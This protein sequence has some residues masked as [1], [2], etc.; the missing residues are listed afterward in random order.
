[1]T[2]IVTGA[3]GCI[4]YHIVK[5]LNDQDV[6]PVVLIRQSSNV[7]KLDGLKCHIYRADLANF[8]QL[9]YVVKQ[10]L[11]GHPP[12]DTIYHCAANMSS[13]NKHYNQ[14]YQDNV[15]ITENICNIVE[16]FNIR[17]LVFTSTGATLPYVNDSP[18]E[19]GQIT[20]PYIKTK[21]IAEN[22]ILHRVSEKRIDAVIVNPII[23]IGSH[24]YNN[25]IEFFKLAAKDKLIA[26]PGKIEFVDARDVAIGHLKAAKYGISGEKYVLGGNFM[27]WLEFSHKIARYVKCRPPTRCLSKSE[28]I[29]IGLW[30]KVCHLFGGAE[31]KLS[32]NT[33]SLLGGENSVP[34][35]YKIKTTEHLKYS[36][37]PIDRAIK[38]CH[39]WAL[40]SG[41][42]SDNS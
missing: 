25:Y 2:A 17:R 9:L 23:V 28:L 39:E 10:A 5:K 7:K 3:T 27:S 31:P 13:S 33:I 6:T 35:Y 29:T 26:L 8:S 36:P 34:I 12:P 4:G 24:D 15:V 20:S 42:Y 40:Q 37:R 30:Q 11:N 41:I 21:K 18:Q 38:D 16:I 22:V 32:L 14:I 19:I 1:M